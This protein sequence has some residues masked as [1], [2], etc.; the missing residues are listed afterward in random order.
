LIQELLGPERIFLGLRGDLP[1]VLSRFLASSSCPLPAEAVRSAILT[2]DAGR[3]EFASDSVAIPHLRIEGLAEPEAFLGIMP[4]G[5]AIKDRKANVILLLITPAE[6]TSRHLQLLERLYAV[7]PAAR[8]GL[9][10][11]GSAAEALQAIA[12]A[13]E[14]PGRTSYINLTQEQVAHELKTHLD[15][16]LSEEEAAR[17]LAFHGSNLLRRQGKPSWFSRLCGNL[18]SFF[19][20]LLWIAAGL[21]FV[22]GVD[23]PQLGLAIL[24]VILANGFFAFI[25]EYQ[26]ERAVEALARLLA[27]RSRVLR[28]G[29]LLEIDAARIVPGDVV[30]L[31][32]GDVVPADGRL[33]EAIEMEV[34]NS[35][36]TG[37][38][39]SSRRYKSDRPVLLSG[40]FLW[41]ELPNIV[42]A[43]TSVVRGRGRAVVF[44][45]G[46]QSEIGNIAAMTQAIAVEESPLQKELRG[47]VRVIAGLAGCFGL[48]FLFLGWLLAD[49]GFIQALVFCIGIFV[50]NVPEG[51]LPTVTLSLAMGVKRMAGRNALVKSLPAVETLGCTTVICSD[52]TGTLTRN[53]MTVNRIFTDGELVEVTGSGYLPEGKFFR[54][55]KEL[56]PAEV[57]R[58]TALWKLIECAASCNNAGLVRTGRDTAVT[59]D[60]TEAALLA[61]AQKAGW[62]GAHQR[63]HLNPF[64]SIRKRMSVVVQPAGQPGKIAWV[65]GAPLEILDRCAMAIWEGRAR[66]LDEDL[67]RRIIREHDALAKQGMRLLGLAYRD[68]EDLQRLESYPVGEVESQLVFL[69][70]TAMSDPVRSGVPEAIR[71]CHTAG[72]RIIMITGDYSL[73]AESVGREVGL[74][75]K[76]GLKVV[77]GGELAELSDEELRRLLADGESIFARVSPQQKLRIVSL[78]KDLGEIVAVTGDGV[79][80]APALKKADIGIAMG[81]RG[82]DVAR[83]A[84]DMV[85]TDDN[86]SSIVAAIEEGRAVFDNIK[87]F[88]AYI[89]NSNPQEMYPYILWM[90]F[91]GVPL[92]MTVMGVLAVDVGT[93]LIPA[94]GLGREPPEPGI[95]KRPPRSRREKILSLPFVLNAYFVQG[96]ILAFS[97]F[98][99]Y[100]YFG[101]ISGCWRPGLPLAAMPA[102]PP[103]LNM[104]EASLLY[105]QSLTAY[106]LPTVTAQIANVLCKRSSTLSLFSRDFLS[107]P[108]RREILE[109]IA[110]WRLFR[111]KKKPPR[112]LRD[113]RG[114]EHHRIRP[115]L[116][117]LAARLEKH[118]LLLNLFSNPLINLGILFELLLCA[119]FFYTPLAGFYYFAPVPWH[120]YLFASSGTLLLLGFEE[121]RKYWLR[122]KA[123]VR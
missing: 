118:Y 88:T 7:L 85:L 11:A 93:D 109:A 112:L 54:N 82:S 67:K 63:L 123:R 95:M 92:A 29:K 83:E 105:L 78:L 36:L 20:V 37:E 31:E 14:Q 111:L 15:R 68:D 116:V 107:S 23:M 26:S 39:T 89:L 113:G 35:S 110:G 76:G 9:L 3:F 6:Q 80:D 44:G 42:F 8:S 19:A 33:I 96:S 87:R 99:C 22:P 73:T 69:G 38:S 13:D 16:G 84:A 43:G 117:K 101:W 59:G 34:D 77:A 45:T 108:R 81:K 102:S 119:L 32:E 65:K 57:S 79:N 53:L 17:R 51:L 91:P 103:G 46:M 98:A 121:G 115:M 41:I 58:W 71:A 21:C 86:F 48:V 62:R 122:K 114:A 90:M 60:P 66:H 30:V 27:P 12:L 104:A 106:F 75:E 10:R 50:A 18:F 25:Q 28:D 5:I 40:K 56:S 100:L 1:S 4:E 120:V 64:E 94:M 74:G 24:A 72:I 52:K 97:C 70:I 49:L 47:A 2:E 55:G 61:V